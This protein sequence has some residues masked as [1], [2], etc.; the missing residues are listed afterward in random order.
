MSKYTFILNPHAGKGTGRRIRDRVYTAAR[1]HTS[2]FELIE[3]S[4]PGDATRIARDTPSAIVVAVG[5]DGTIHEIVNG[6]VGTEKVLGII[7]IGSG[8]DFIKSIGVP[9]QI[10]EASSCLF[11]QK[12]MRIDLGKLE[13]STNGAG[14][15]GNSS[16]SFFVNG[17]GIGFDAAVA[18]RTRQISW[19]SGSMLYIIA[20]LQTLGRY[21]SPEFTTIVDGRERTSRH[22][23]I[24]VG[25]GKCAGGG[26]YLTPDAKVDDAMLDL[27]L[28]D[29][30]SPLAIIRLMPRAMK[31]SHGR[32]KSVKFE[33]GKEIDVS[34]SSPVSVHADG[35]IV[36]N[37]VTALKIAIAPS[38]MNV[39]AGWHS[40]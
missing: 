32:S 1:E 13:I 20:V 36:G 34:M 38:S 11:R 14:N 3:T 16:Q 30:I 19:I 9:K 26:F 31:G 25:N 18:S 12:V 10:E 35:E 6:I 5:G 22:L 37:A 17:V 23:L 33:R 8:N 39:I 4:C 21:K 28:I 40:W 7:P 15:P 2:D 27:C 29:D 24:A